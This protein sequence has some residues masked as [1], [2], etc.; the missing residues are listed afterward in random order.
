MPFFLMQIEVLVMNELA[1]IKSG[2]RRQEG[3]RV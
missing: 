2:E 3:R 1:D